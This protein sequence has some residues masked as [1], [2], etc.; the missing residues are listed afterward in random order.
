MPYLDPGYFLSNR[1]MKPLFEESQRIVLELEVWRNEYR[2][3]LEFII[4]SD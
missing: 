2:L 4:L 1:I 3:L